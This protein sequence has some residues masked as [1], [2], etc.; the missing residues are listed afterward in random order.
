MIRGG[1]LGPPTVPVVPAVSAVPMSGV[2]R[3]R[4]LLIHGVDCRRGMGSLV[5]AARRLRVGECTVGGE[6]WLLGQA[7]IGVSICYQWW[8]T[9]T[10]LL[11]YEVTQCHLVV[12]FILSSAMSLGGS[13]VV[14][15]V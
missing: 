1:L 5:V 11:W 9:W 15:V 4:A 14:Y 6:R 8:Y 2:I 10:A 3:V 7:G 12:H 13:G